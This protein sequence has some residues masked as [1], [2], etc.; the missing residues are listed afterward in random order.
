MRDGVEQADDGPASHGAGTLL[1][2]VD[3]D[4]RGHR[5]LQRSWVATCRLGRRPGERLDLALEVVGGDEQP[6]ADAVAGGRG[7]FDHPRACGGKDDR[8]PAPR[9]RHDPRLHVVC[10]TADLDSVRGLAL[11]EGAQDGQV[12]TSL[13]HRS[14][15]VHA[16]QP[17]VE[18]RVAGPHAEREPPTRQVVQAERRGG[19]RLWGTHEH[20]GHIC[21]EPDAL[22]RHCHRRE[23]HEHV[24]GA[25][26]DVDGVDA[27]LLGTAGKV[28]AVGDRAVEADVDGE[29]GG[30]G[31][32]HG[33][34]PACA[35]RQAPQRQH[36]P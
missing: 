28:H 36:A 17:L 2:V 27:G 23:W 22:G 35:E 21:A 26:D 4:E 20:V 13:G 16:E 29:G 10:R 11:Q 6:E 7:Q 31:G 34:A 8:Y 14:S 1:V 18:V 3:A 12:V 30:R 19:R 25:L 32:A 33:F 15:R 5:E 24:T 9:R